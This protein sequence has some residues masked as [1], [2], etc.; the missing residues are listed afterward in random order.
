MK[1]LL[2][3]LFIFLS[4]SAYSQ[5]NV[6]IKFNLPNDPV[7]GNKVK[8][9]LTGVRFDQYGKVL[10]VS[11]IIKLT[12]PITDLDIPVTSEIQD[13]SFYSKE[14]NYTVTG[15]SILSTTR[16]Y[17][18]MV[19][20]LGVV[21]PDAIMIDD[22]LQLKNLNAFKNPNGTNVAGGDASWRFIQSVL[23]EIILIKQANA[24]L[25]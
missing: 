10:S 20:G 14:I 5:G 1:K 11:Y 19:T 24:Q 9:M 25:P 13:A 7:T 2:V 22:Y 21:I 8:V 3:I 6:Q 17:S 23:N 15:K 16:V 18:P 4:L 12:N